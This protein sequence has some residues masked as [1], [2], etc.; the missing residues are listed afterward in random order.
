[1]LV[2]L[3]GAGQALQNGA[4]YEFNKWNTKTLFVWTEYTTVPY[5]GLQAG[6]NIRLTMDDMEA[7]RNNIDGIDQISPRLYLN[8]DKI[9][10]NNK[11]GAY[12]V[13]GET[14]ALINIEPI[15][16]AQGRFINPRDLADKR[17]VIVIGQ[18]VKDVLFGEEDPIGQYLEVRGAWFQV[19]G[20]AKSERGGGESKEDDESIF[21]PITTMQYTFNM[22]GRVH[23]FVTTVK[24]DAVSA[25]VSDDMKVLLRA[26]HD[27]A[28]N[29]VQ[30]IGSF[31]LEEEFERFQGIFV[32]IKLIVLLVSFGTIIA[33]VIGVANIMIIIVKERTKEIGV[34]KAMGA[35][36][37]SIV[38]MILQESIFLTTISGYLGLMA[39]MGILIVAGNILAE[40]Q[41][42]VQ[43]FRN[44]EIRIEIALGAL[45]FLIISGA[46]AGAIPGRSA[47][48]I[49]PATTLREE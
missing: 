14:D 32:G 48:K 21:M 22:I 31:N 30:A 41:G 7:V 20:V 40:V 44:P 27:V 36:D 6:R 15:A 17:K 42:E 39:A 4:T 18:R 24:A 34:R 29:D 8:V 25:R 28:P 1:M 9:V 37:S 43:F 46:I 12:S 33:G 45:A 26:R 10:R 49:N 38:A 16:M 5:K 19:V 47:A 11:E 13:R 3:M 2:I 35:T 23:W